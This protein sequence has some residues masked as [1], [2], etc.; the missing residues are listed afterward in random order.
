MS[1]N[2]NWPHAW[3][4]ATVR[5]TEGFM[6]IQMANISTKIG[7]TTQ[8]HLSIHIR[9]VHINLA[10]MSMNHLANFRNPFFKNAVSGRIGHHQ[11][12]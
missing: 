8:A 9:A 10:A 6:E 1:F 11:S 3:P 5:N 7:G 4:T 12:G 2:P